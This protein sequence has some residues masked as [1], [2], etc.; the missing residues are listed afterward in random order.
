MPKKRMSSLHHSPKARLS[1]C[2]AT[3]MLRKSAKASMVAMIASCSRVTGGA[4]TM[5]DA[6]GGSGS[7]LTFAIFCLPVGARSVLILPAVL[8]TGAVFAI[9]VLLPSSVLAAAFEV[10]ARTEAQVSSIRAYRDTDPSN[11]VLLPRRRLVQ[12]LGIDAFELIPDAPL[13]FES[14]LRVFA[15]FGLPLGES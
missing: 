13:G 14:S 12:Y 11:P 15:D 3:P 5:A 9:G 10:D 7:G 4:E 8:R 1:S 6:G 2:V